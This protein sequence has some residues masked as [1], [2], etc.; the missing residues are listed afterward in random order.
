MIG[1]SFGACLIKFP[2]VVLKKS[3][4]SAIEK[5]EESVQQAVCILAEAVD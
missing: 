4:A 2:S 3:S 1:D 5:R